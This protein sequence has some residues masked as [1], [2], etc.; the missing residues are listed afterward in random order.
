MAPTAHRDRV[1]QVDLVAVEIRQSRLA[2]RR[3]A[4]VHELRRRVIGRESRDRRTVEDLHV[5][6]VHHRRADD[7]LIAALPAVGASR[8]RAAGARKRQAAD[9]ALRVRVAEAVHVRF[10]R[11][12]PSGAHA[13][14]HARVQQHLLVRTGKD[15]IRRCGR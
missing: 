13:M 6:I 1:G 15:G 11:Q 14:V 7:R 2:D 3:E 10:H 5:R 9:N 4:W 12:R 8:E